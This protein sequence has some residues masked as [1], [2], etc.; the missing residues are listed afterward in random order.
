MD[1]EILVHF[2]T[3]SLSWGF[4]RI[5]SLPISMDEMSLT[6]P[7]PI[8]VCSSV[9]RRFA[10]LTPLAGLVPFIGI[11][12]LA[13]EAKQLTFLPGHEYGAKQPH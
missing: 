1:D 10:P 6:F 13:D 11:W 8:Y 2:F 4:C 7:L 9:P 5:V 3:R 12:A